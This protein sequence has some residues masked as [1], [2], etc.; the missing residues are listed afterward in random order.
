MLQFLIVLKPVFLIQ[1]LN[2]PVFV[3]VVKMV[4][5]IQHLVVL[6]FVLV[7]VMHLAQLLVVQGP[8][9]FVV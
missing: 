8:L 5:K 6:K 9:N 3:L 1:R 2:L 4:E 7:V